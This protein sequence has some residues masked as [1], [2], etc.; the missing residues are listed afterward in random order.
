M[1]VEPGALVWADVLVPA[2][3]P[4]WSPDVGW[5]FAWLGGAWADALA[6]VGVP[7]AHVHGGPLLKAS[8]SATVCFAGLGPGEVT[9]GGAKVVGMCQRRARAG[10]LFQCAA[11]L[12]WEPAHLLDVL[13]LTAED[14]RRGVDE[15]GSVARGLDVDAGAL[16]EAFIA[17]LP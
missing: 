3:D 6:D 14:R 15:L 1:L 9:L 11:L 7:G 17:R 16:V 8:W 12:S 4:L 13:D 5:A 10:S 2:G